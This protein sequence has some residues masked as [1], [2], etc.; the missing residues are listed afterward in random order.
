MAKKHIEKYPN[1]SV[2]R[3]LQIKVIISHYINQTGK[4]F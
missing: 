1:S 3:E 2:V 4:N